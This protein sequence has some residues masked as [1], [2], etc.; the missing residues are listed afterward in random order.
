[1]ELRCIQRLGRTAQLLC[2]SYSPRCTSRLLSLYRHN[3][4]PTQLTWVLPIKTKMAHSSVEMGA[5]PRTRGIQSSEM[6]ASIS[7]LCRL[8][9]RNEETPSRRATDMPQGTR[10][11]HHKGETTIW[12]TIKRAKWCRA[13][14][15]ASAMEK[16]NHA[17]TMPQEEGTSPKTRT[18]HAHNS[19][20]RQAEPTAETQPPTAR[21]AST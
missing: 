13:M 21:R 20:T 15:L 5:W 11:S 18:I 17:V 19:Q 1:M 14:T 8:A 2:R 7:K 6:I 4:A 12:S 10:S 9:R 3:K 16:A